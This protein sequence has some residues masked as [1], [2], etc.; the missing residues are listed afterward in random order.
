M[1]QFTHNILKLWLLMVIGVGVAIG[2]GAA[3]PSSTRP[4]LYQTGTGYHTDI[5][6]LDPIRQVTIRLTHH[7]ARDTTPTWRPRGASLSFASNRAADDLDLYHMTLPSRQVRLLKDTDQEGS[8]LHWSP[9]GDHAAY[10]EGSGTYIDLFL[11]QA[12]GTSRPLT[13]DGIVSSIPVWSPDGQRVAYIN[14]HQNVPDIY[15]AHIDARTPRR[16]TNGALA[17]SPV[18]SP[19]GTQIAYSARSERNQRFIYMADIETGERRHI[20]AGADT[21]LL[22][23][24]PTAGHIA[25][26]AGDGEERDLHLAMLDWQA[27]NDLALTTARLSNGLIIN[28]LNW[29]ADGEWLTFTARR[30]PGVW[31]DTAA[32]PLRYRLRALI[33]RDPL[34]ELQREEVYIYRLGWAAPRRVTFN[35]AFDISPSWQP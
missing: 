10:L 6:L 28:A 4:I 22:A 3:T 21:R 15:I 25:Y 9:D 2:T 19:D 32:G 12:D 29:S 24:S 7:P 16:L 35:T 1:T 27:E 33:S 31:A 13:Q 20:L 11:L 26:I 18:W 14:A 8:A 23:W 17:S 5:A 30:V 34:P